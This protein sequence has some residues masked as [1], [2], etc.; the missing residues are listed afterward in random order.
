MAKKKLY[1]LQARPITTLTSGNL[2]TYEI[3]ETL[4]RDALWVNTNVGEAVPDV[5]TPFTWSLLRALDI[6]SGFVPGY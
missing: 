5:V 3:N 6:E 1:I 4:E 2:D